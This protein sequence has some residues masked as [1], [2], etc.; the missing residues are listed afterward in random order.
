MIDFMNLIDMAIIGAIM[1][2]MEVLKGFDKEKKLARFY[3]LAVLL[4]GL[5]AAAFKAVPF[6][7]QTFGYNTLLY[8]GASSF[9]FK[10]GKT[11]VLG[12]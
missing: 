9:V 6:T 5:A 8:V 3:P 11:T 2:L 12:K 4:M 10:F 7:W 1:G